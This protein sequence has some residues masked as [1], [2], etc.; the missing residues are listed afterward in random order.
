VL[1]IS[2]AENC[3]W[4]MSGARAGEQHAAFTGV[5]VVGRTETLAE[6]NSKTKWFKDAAAIFGVAPAAR[7]NS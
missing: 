7:K 5:R 2:N 6:F 4:N 3:R 1:D